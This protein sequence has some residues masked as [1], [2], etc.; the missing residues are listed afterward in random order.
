[1]NDQVFVTNKNAERHTDRYDGT[2]Y[3]FPS[4]EK[5]LVSIEAARLFFGFGMADKTEALVRQGW[6]NS[7]EGVTRLARFVFTQG[8][9]VEVPMKST[10]QP[11]L[12]AEV[13]EE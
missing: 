8:V 11:I 7:E 13:V 6:A 5:V 1:M 4:G 9:M 2:D 3:D 12:D 10:G